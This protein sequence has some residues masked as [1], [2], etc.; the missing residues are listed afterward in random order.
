MKPNEFIRKE[1]ERRG[2]TQKELAEKIGVS[3][4]AVTKYE[5]GT[6]TPSDSV[7]VA[8][9]KLFNQTVGKIFFANQ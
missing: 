7:K 3:Q 4:E 6:R 5:A 1:R 2:W 8:I 9:A